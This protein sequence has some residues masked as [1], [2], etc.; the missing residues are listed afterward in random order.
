MS[1]DLRE[2]LKRLAEEWRRG[3]RWELSTRGYVE[4]G[5]MRVGLIP[6]P[7]KYIRDGSA[8]NDWID[9]TQPVTHVFSWRRNA[10]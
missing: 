4:M 8:A 6:P 5:F 9:T 2:V 3:Y 10:D 7:C 1:A